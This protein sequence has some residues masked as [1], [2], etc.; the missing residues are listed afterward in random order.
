MARHF[1]DR[2]YI[3]MRYA[4]VPDGALARIDL[5]GRPS[6]WFRNGPAARAIIHP[7]RIA[8]VAC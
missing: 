7:N 8:Q 6:G 3:E 1:E 4:D 2:P 5:R